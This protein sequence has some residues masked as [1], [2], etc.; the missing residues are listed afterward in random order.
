MKFT[1]F[2]ESR[3]ILI[4][5]GFSIILSLYLVLGIITSAFLGFEIPLLSKEVLE[6]LFVILGFSLFYLFVV[7]SWY[8]SEGGDYIS[9]AFLITSI[10]LPFFISIYS[11]I[12]YSPIYLI[13]LIPI[14]LSPVVTA[15]EYA[16]LLFIKN[17]TKDCQKRAKDLFFPTKVALIMLLFYIII[18]LILIY[19]FKENVELIGKHF[20]AI[21][22]IWYLLSAY[23]NVKHF[24]RFFNKSK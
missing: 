1:Q 23:M 20:Y 17:K 16:T 5:N 14:F 19:I 22:I 24:K 13:N 8:S 2:K 11:M 15:I 12:K 10:M 4:S 6:S 21:P 9:Y 3:P 18:W 7:N